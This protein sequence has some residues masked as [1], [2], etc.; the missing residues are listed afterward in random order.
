M[1]VRA[2]ESRRFRASLDE[3]K[4]E[5]DAGRFR[6]ARKGLA[7]LSGRHTNH[8]EVEYLSG[9]CEQAIGHLDPALAAWGRVP[10]GTAFTAKAR[11]A[12]ARSMMLERGRFTLAEE[13][14][15]EAI[16]EKGSDGFEARQMLAWLLL[17]QGRTDESRSL[18]ESGWHD[19]PDQHAL[20][21]ELWQIDRE[22]VLPIESIRDGLER[23]ARMAP[24][25]D[26]A[27]LGRGHLST[28][29]G[30]FDEADRWLEACIEARPND[31][32]V[33]ASA[34][35]G[36]YPPVEPTRHGEPSPE[37]RPARLRPMRSS[38]SSPGSH[39]RRDDRDAERAALKRLVALSPCD[40]RALDR[41]AA[42]A[43]E[44]G[45]AAEATEFRRCVVEAEGIKARYRGSLGVQDPGGACLGTGPVGGANGPPLRGVGL[46]DPGGAARS[47]SSCLLAGTRPSRQAPAGHPASGRLSARSYTRRAGALRR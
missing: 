1:I 47:R 34:S 44:G 25:D 23:A 9:I 39:P 20:L 33:C 30:E 10:A 5:L 28:L 2:R 7:R 15:R 24:R 16:R 19:A 13:T 40:T 6:L 3:V 46:V 18:L 38:R 29:S 27:W 11:L 32:A 36:P 41:L 4:Q 12:A 42:I 22:F 14:L 35:I 43:A 37:S 26:R 17:W 21:R 45:R 31:A 8:P